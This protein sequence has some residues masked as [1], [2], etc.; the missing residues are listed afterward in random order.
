MN[1]EEFKLT[2]KR[3]QRETGEFFNSIYNLIQHAEA[4]EQK[5]QKQYDEGYQKGLEDAWEMIRKIYLSPDEGGMEINEIFEYLGK[6]LGDILRNNSASEAKAKY[7]AWKAKK[8]QEDEIRVGDVVTSP[9]AREYIVLHISYDDDGIKTFT[10]LEV[11]TG[12]VLHFKECF[13]EKTGKHYDL[14]W[15]QET[16]NDS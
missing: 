9:S 16:E 3:L 13:L 1:T 11:S 4:V 5:A 10:V 7:D 2:R 6:G 12:F 8:E 15:L 14:P